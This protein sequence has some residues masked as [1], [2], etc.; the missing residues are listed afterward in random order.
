MKSGWHRSYN[1]F[2]RGLEATSDPFF[3]GMAHRTVS[4]ELFEPKG[5]DMQTPHAQDELYIVRQGHGRLEKAGEVIDVATGDVMMIEA[6]VDHRFVTFSEDFSVWVIFYGPVH[7]Q[8][9]PDADR[10]DETVRS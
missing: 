7:A 5:R 9:N 3:Q 8:G 4:V 6:G 10:R 1:Y 2:R